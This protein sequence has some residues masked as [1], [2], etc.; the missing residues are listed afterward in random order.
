[1]VLFFL[2]FARDFFKEK[3]TERQTN[4]DKQFAKLMSDYKEHLAQLNN[5]LVFMIDDKFRECLAQYEVIAPVPS[6]CFRSICQQITRVHEIVSQLLGE[7][8]IIVLFTEIHDKFKLRL[9][10][11]LRELNVVNDG[12]PQHAY[13]D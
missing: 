3:L 7:Q 8:T 5:K 13:V 12:G 6:Q 4:A 10:E 11:R 9:K 1:V 2:P